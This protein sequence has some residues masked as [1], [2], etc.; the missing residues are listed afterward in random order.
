MLSCKQ[1][2]ERVTD[3]AEGQLGVMDRLWFWMHIS[4]CANC[5]T[6]VRQLQATAKA[7]GKLPEP[8]IPQEMQDELMRRFEGWTAHR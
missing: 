2:T 3:D 1:I 6:H 4:I 5:K 7:L 8:Q